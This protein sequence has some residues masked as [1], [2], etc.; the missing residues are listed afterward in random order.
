MAEQP[1]GDPRQRCFYILRRLIDMRVGWHELDKDTAKRMHDEV[2]K[3]DA[4]GKDCPDFDEIKA[5]VTK[6]KRR[7]RAA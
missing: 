7:K 1:N 4:G 6:P 2:D 3:I 5:K